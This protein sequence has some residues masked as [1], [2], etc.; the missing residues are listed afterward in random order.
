MCWSLTK[1][2][3]GTM[4]K[5]KRQNEVKRKKERKERRKGREA[6]RFSRSNLTT[7]L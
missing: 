3:E 1:I 2:M 4:R 7:L 6:V 5:K